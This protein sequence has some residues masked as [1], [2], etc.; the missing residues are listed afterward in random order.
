MARVAR[1]VLP[2]GKARRHGAARSASL[3]ALVNQPLALK[4]L[5]LRGQIFAG[6]ALL[7]QRNMRRLSSVAVAVYK[8][9]AVAQPLIVMIVSNSDACCPSSS[10]STHP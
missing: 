7:K 5:R 6:A 8:T 10:I 1:L 4:G 3:S 9:C 2:D